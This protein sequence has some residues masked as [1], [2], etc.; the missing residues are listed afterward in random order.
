MWLVI[1]T[2]FPS[3][4][5]DSSW[6]SNHVI[7]FNAVLRTCGSSWLLLWCQYMVFKTIK[8]IF[9][10]EDQS[11]SFGQFVTGL[12]KGKKLKACWKNMALTSA[13]C[14]GETVSSTQTTSKR[15]RKTIKKL[16]EKKIT[17]LIFS[18]KV[19]IS[20]ISKDEG[21]IHG[22]N[23]AVTCNTCIVITTHKE[24]FSQRVTCC[25]FVCMAFATI[26]NYQWLPVIQNSLVP[27][28]GVWQAKRYQIIM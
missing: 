5:A 8:I 19:N 7:W 3:P 12:Q 15:T 11:Y 6:L 18:A 25:R 14:C 28:T 17:I 27:I 9:P 4:S 13:M 1:N 22:L 23:C 20:I 24:G 26:T 16:K 2:F 10:S 21:N